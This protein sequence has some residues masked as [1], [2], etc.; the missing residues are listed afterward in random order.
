MRAA[1]VSVVIAMAIGSASGASATA[2]ASGLAGDATPTLSAGAPGEVAVVAQS[3]PN[4]DRVAVIVRNDT[5]GPVN[6]V[7]ID[8]TATRADGGAVTSA[9]TSSL[10]PATLA[11]GAYGLAVLDF[12]QQGVDIDSQLS[13]TLR[14]TKTASGTDPKLLEVSELTRSAP[15]TGKVAQKLTFTVANPSHRA[16]RGPITATVM[17]FNEAGKPVNL[18]TARVRRTGLRAGKDASVSVGLAELCPAA[19]V[20][21]RAA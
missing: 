5:T 13:F 3:A 9:S 15:M 2:P 18:T 11:P 6:N 8:A 20:G 12:R 10:V 17:C 7:R 16:V 19:L 14:S 21:A 1:I 4:H